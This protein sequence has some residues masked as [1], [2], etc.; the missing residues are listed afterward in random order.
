M[1]SNCLNG[2]SHRIQSVFICLFLWEKKTRRARERERSQFDIV[3]H[4]FLLSLFSYKIYLSFFF[5]PWM[6]KYLS[7]FYY[8]QCYCSIVIRLRCLSIHCIF[9]LSFSRRIWNEDIINKR[10]RKCWSVDNSMM[11][12]RCVY[13]LSVTCGRD[14]L[15]VRLNK[16]GQLVLSFLCFIVPDLF[17]FELIR[18]N[19]LMIQTFPL[20]IIAIN[21]SQQGCLVLN[22]TLGREIRAEW[23]NLL[24]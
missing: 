11:I 2:V 1:M 5:S 8:I 21:A 4:N 20:I 17:L 19:F 15:R 16:Q 14:I 9:D 18:H 13:M 23:V 7:R 12:H 22:F 3:N 6:L 10:H 24:N